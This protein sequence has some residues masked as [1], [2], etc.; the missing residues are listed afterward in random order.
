MLLNYSAAS[1]EGL[2]PGQRALGLS[3]AVKFSFLVN[4]LVSLPMY[5]WPYQVG[6]LLTVGC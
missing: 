2:A 4:G 6:G 5:L 1:L 3:A